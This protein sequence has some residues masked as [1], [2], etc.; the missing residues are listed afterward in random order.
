MV[1]SFLNIKYFQQK[2]A[3]EIEKEQ[4]KKFLAQFTGENFLKK[5]KR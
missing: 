4:Y 1:L 2:A 3:E 5:V